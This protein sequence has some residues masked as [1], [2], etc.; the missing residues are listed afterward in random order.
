VLQIRICIDLD[1]TI[2]DEPNIEPPERYKHVKPYPEVVQML[3]KF[4]ERGHHITIHSARFEC[5]REITEKFLKEN[6]IPY[7]EL[8]LGK[9]RAEI[10]IDN[11]SI[12]LNEEGFDNFAL[13]YLEAH[14]E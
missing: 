8:I 12:R 4:H 6:K 14:K 13:Q 3:R 1:G 9:P 5:D 10:Y 7:D 2:C 11:R